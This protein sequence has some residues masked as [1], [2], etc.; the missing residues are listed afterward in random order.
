MIIGW[1]NRADAGAISASS[2]VGTLP[3]SNVQQRHVSRPWRTLAGVNSAYLVLDLGSALACRL[4]GLMG[5]N[6]TAAATVRL[7]ASNADPAAVS[8][9]LLD[10]GV[11]ATTAKAGYGQ[12]YHAFTET[13]ARY[14][15]L[16]I[17]D[18]SLSYL[19]IGRLFL[20]PAWS[21][22]VNQEYG[23]GVSVIDPSRVDMSY[24]GQ[25]I[26]DI[27]PQQ[28]QLQ[29]TLN[30]MNEAEMYGNAF[31]A[32]RALGLVGHGLFVHD[33]L[34]GARIAEQSVWGRIVATVE[35]AQQNARIF[36]NKFTV[37]EVL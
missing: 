7:R 18:A 8:S 25:D 20:G 33:S 1:I 12:S 2:E 27:R 37:L 36:R 19:N 13:T 26:P 28:R 32:A 4:L 14:W 15:R 10:T 34:G 5:T 35:I 17:S 24:G 23:W 16:D 11:I 3:A 22:S 31:A 6:L 9:L 29:F 21:P 30:W